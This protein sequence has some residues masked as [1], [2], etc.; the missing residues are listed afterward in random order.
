MP[1]SS[2]SKEAA[3]PADGRPRHLKVVQSMN[4]L[5]SP[6]GGLARSLPGRSTQADVLPIRTPDPPLESGRCSTGSV[7]KSSS[8]PM[9]TDELRSAF[10][11]TSMAQLADLGD[12]PATETLS[13][14]PQNSTHDPAVSFYPTKKREPAQDDR[15]SAGVMRGEM[16]SRAED[17]G[18]QIFPP[19]LVPSVPCYLDPGKHQQTR[20]SPAAPAATTTELTRL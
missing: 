13:P 17:R 5:P 12:A 3:A 10:R 8:L 9:R 14:T 4:R 1:M 20:M 16:W 2:S 15:A 6:G 19:S 18:R 7:Q 11:T